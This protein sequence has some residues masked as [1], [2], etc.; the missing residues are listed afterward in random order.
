MPVFDLSVMTQ[1]VLQVSQTVELVQAS[2]ANLATLSD[3]AYV[4]QVATQV[5]EVSMEVQTIATQLAGRGSLWAAL[6]HSNGLPT[7]A[8]GLMAWNGQAASL[9]NTCLQEAMQA[10]TILSGAVRTLEGLTRAI[11]LVAGL[12]GNKAG[13]Q[14][15]TA[16]TATLTNETIRLQASAASFQQAMMGGSMISMVNE[17]VTVRLTQNRFEG[18]GTIA[19]R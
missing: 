17:L 6:T 9:A 7:T 2:A 13:F 18:W 16:L 8:A 12:A 10:Q 3:M 4:S 5:A 15:L 11:S 1:M 14:A 19:P